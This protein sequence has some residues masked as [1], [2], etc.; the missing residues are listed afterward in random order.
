MQTHNQPASGSTPVSNSTLGGLTGYGNQIV[1]NLETK[2]SD[3]LLALETALLTQQKVL[4]VNQTLDAELQKTRGE[5]NTMF[6]W[7]SQQVKTDALS[8][9]LQHH[10]TQAQS[11]QQN[12]QTELDSQ[13][14]KEENENKGVSEPVQKYLSSSGPRSEYPGLVSS[15]SLRNRR[16]LH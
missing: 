11:E 12:D 5:S 13:L 2:Q 7:A 3:L 9:K 6:Q 1:A 15:R 10:N 8:C 16:N 4:D 14:L